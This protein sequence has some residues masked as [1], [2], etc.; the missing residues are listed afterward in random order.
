M[1]CMSLSQVSL[2]I[3]V[4][5]ILRFFNLLSDYKNVSLIVPILLLPF[6]SNEQQV[7][8]AL[9]IKVQAIDLK[10]GHLF[11]V[12]SITTLFSVVAILITSTPYQKTNLGYI[13]FQALQAS[14]IYG[15]NLPYVLFPS[16]ST[17]GVSLEYYIPFTCTYIDVVTL[18]RM[19]ILPSPAS[20]SA[21]TSCA[22][23]TSSSGL[24]V[25]DFPLM[26]RLVVLPLMTLALILSVL[27]LPTLLIAHY[28]A[29]S[30]APSKG[31]CTQQSLAQPASLLCL[32]AF[33]TSDWQLLH[34]FFDDVGE[35]G[36]E[37]ENL[38]I[39]RI[40]Q[41]MVEYNII[42]VRRIQLITTTGKHKYNNLHKYE[43]KGK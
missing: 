4:F 37:G 38:S 32:V 43:G 12:T 27:C 19:G 23:R 18:K 35:R 15:A 1:S 40:Q 42:L 33:T 26:T 31:H 2:C 20:R 14:T 34:R 9:N 8:F 13:I 16:W 28:S 11:F 41:L 25:G 29:C 7:H 30:R 3:S 22:P 36:R 5:Q 39:T 6:L 24:L 10:Q 21:A 17:F